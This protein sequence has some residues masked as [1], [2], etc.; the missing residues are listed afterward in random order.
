[1]ETLREV[2]GI[3]FILFGVF[4]CSMGVLGL[5][6]FPDVYSRLHAS[7]K[8]STLGIVGLLIGAAF[9]SPDTTLKSIVLVIFLL[10]TAPVASHAIADSAHKS[11]VPVENTERDDLQTAKD[12]GRH[13]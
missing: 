4:F 2:L 7:G 8:V 13:S 10:S 12:E 5:I 3:F 9:I 1:M 6:R 11:G